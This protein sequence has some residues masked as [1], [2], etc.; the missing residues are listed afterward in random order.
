MPSDNAV[1]PAASGRLRIA[2]N[3]GNPIL[4]S[5]TSVVEKPAGLALDLGKALAKRLGV[6]PAFMEFK[7]AAQCMRELSQGNADLSFMA[8]DPTRS[9]DVHFSSPY[10]EISGAFA[11]RAHSAIQ[12]NEEV[13]RPSHEVVVGVGSAYDLFLSRHLEHANLH[14]IPLSEH[15]IE[16]M[17]NGHYTAAAGI[18]QQLEDLIK[19]NTE[20]RL[21]E[22]NFM[23]IQQAIALSPHCETELHQ[24]VEGFLSWARSSGLIQTSLSEHGIP[25]ARIAQGEPHSEV[26]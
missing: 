5:S 24:Q 1:N 8:I 26:D 11:V 21:L 22:E 18:R 16:E 3:M 13:D 14:R 12:T 20:V 10:V 9:K 19:P 17:L 4:T 2:L 15:V 25:G 7:T 6:E 23:V